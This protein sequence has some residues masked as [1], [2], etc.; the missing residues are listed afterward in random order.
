MEFEKSS[1]FFQKNY[2]FTYPTITGDKVPI[3]EGFLKMEFKYLIFSEIIALKVLYSDFM[4]GD[5]R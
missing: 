1:Q 3:R 2:I 4:R 5:E